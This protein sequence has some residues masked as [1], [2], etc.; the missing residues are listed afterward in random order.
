[1]WYRVSVKIDDSL[2]K[3]HDVHNKLYELLLKEIQSDYPE[4]T[5]D[6]IKESHV[7]WSHNI[8]HEYGY[9]YYRLDYEEDLEYELQREIRSREFWDDCRS[10][11]RATVEDIFR[12]FENDRRRSRS[13]IRGDGNRPR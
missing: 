8:D 13:H 1:M 12:A 11:G 2:H 9:E 7:E 10:S 5:I 6:D 4:F 3:V